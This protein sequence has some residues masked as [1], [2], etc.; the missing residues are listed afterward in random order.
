MEEKT[1]GIVIKNVDSGDRDKLITI[2]T[3]QGLVCAK[4]KGVNSATSKLKFAKQTF[5]FADF[6]FASGKFPVV[7]SAYLIDSF[8]DL[9]KD[10]D[11]F[12]EA[13]KILRVAKPLM[14]ENEPNPQLFVALLKSFKNLAYNNVQKN[15]VYAK[16]MLGLFYNQGYAFD[17]ETCSNCGS[18]LNDTR[19]LNL[20]NGETLCSFCKNE[21]CQKINYG[22]NK[23]LKILQQTDFDDLHTI[24]FGKQI[25]LDTLQ[26]LLK[27]YTN[28]VI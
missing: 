1:K 22:M 7:T 21:Y 8:Y 3:P 23:V 18:V 9:T 2:F 24:K 12:D 28:V 17:T 13:S 10:F 20:S 16:F 14:K 11:R 15:I 6:V 26:L 19:Y 27:N 5:C 25:L 4:L